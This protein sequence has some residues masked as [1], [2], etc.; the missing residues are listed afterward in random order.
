VSSLTLEDGFGVRSRFC[1]LLHSAEASSENRVQ[2]H[3]LVH[4][5]VQRGP[6]QIGE[7]RSLRSGR[8]EPVKILKVPGR[9][10]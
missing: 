4:L 3:R 5:A 6:T 10:R 7:R 9:E 1:H 2:Q 8:T